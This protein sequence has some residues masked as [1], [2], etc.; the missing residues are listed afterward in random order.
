[1]PIYF[2][3]T[4]MLLT[5]LLLWKG[6]GY[7]VNLTEPEIAGTIVGVGAAFGLLVSITLVPWMYRVV[8]KEDW[9][10]RW[11]HIP[12]GPLLLRRGDVPPA[13]EDA[14]PTIKDY[15]EGRMTKE[16]LEAKKATQR[17]DVEVLGSSGDAADK[18]TNVEAAAAAEKAAN[19]D[20]SDAASAERP[21]QSP[22]ANVRK[23][24]QEARRPQTRRQVVRGSCSV[25]VCQVGAAARYRPGSCPRREHPQQARQGSGG[26]TCP[27]PAL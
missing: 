6:G 27:R 9:Q 13:P 4:A 15:Y 19:V 2:A 5:M 21:N 14:G 12:L 11:Y 8:I 26:G 7:E 18:T 24:P 25:L 20:G 16:E 23:P 3:L 22:L 1:M 17:G 10:L